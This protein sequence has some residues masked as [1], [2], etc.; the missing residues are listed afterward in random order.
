MKRENIQK[1][2]NWFMMAQGIKDKGHLH[3]AM[4]VLDVWTNRLPTA[5]RAKQRRYMENLFWRMVNVWPEQLQREP[6]VGPGIHAAVTTRMMN[7]DQ[8]ACPAGEAGERSD[9]SGVDGRQGC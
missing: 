4:N 9:P 2:A 7:E 6:I 8:V 3:K 1:L 5:K